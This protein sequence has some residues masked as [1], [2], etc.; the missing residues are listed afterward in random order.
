MGERR[1]W[2]QLAVGVL[3]TATWAAM[4]AASVFTVNNSGD[5]ADF[6][7]GDG[8]CE[9]ASGNG[10][11][12][13]RAAIEE[14]NALAAG[15]PHAIRFN[16]AMT[17]TAG[18][19]LP[20]VSRAGTAIDGATGN[21]GFAGAPVVVVVAGGAFDGLTMAG[22]SGEVRAL[23]LQ[24]FASAIVLASTGNLVRG[25]YIGTDASGS[26]AAANGT[27]LTVTGNGNT[28]GG[29][30]AADR[31]LISGN[32]AVGVLVGGA[33]SCTVQGNLIGLDVSGTTA[34]PNGT[35]GIHISGATATG[36]TVGGLVAGARNVISGHSGGNDAGIFL[37]NGAG[38]NVIQG[39][40]IGTNASGTTAVANYFGINSQS[41]SGNTLGG[42]SAAARNLVSGNSNTGVRLSGSSNNLVQ[43]NFIGLDASGTAALGNGNQGL[44][45]DNASGNTVGGAA[46]GAGNVI[47]GNG[48]V[49]VRLGSASNTTVQGNVIGMDAGATTVIDNAGGG[50]HVFGGT[51][52]RILGNVLASATPTHLGIDLDVD[53]SAPDD[54]VTAN[55]LDDPDTGSNQL[56][57]FPVLSAAETDGFQTDLTGSLNSLPSTTFRIEFFADPACHPLGHGAG[58]VV[59][60]SADVTTDAG[61]DAPIAV[62]LPIGVVVG[63]AVSATATDPA[64][65]TS[66]FSACVTAQA[67]SEPA[68]EPVPASSGPGLLATMLLLAAAGAWLLRVRGTWRAPAEGAR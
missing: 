45:I 57:N 58:R 53:T 31:N 40:Y 54:G 52:N 35:Y 33:Q 61:G 34:V 26:A 8:V 3:V 49:A 42:T 23:V 44:R 43:G 2:R 37:D 18:T 13:L 38:G 28:I 46:A 21:P 68:A 29:T 10:V 15:A 62:S 17:V 55:D 41:A 50:V 12:T 59:L 36:N 16:A 25:C 39:N 14:T 19:A 20:A 32:S 1:L 30:T 63:W 64:G 24:S 48:D 4:A 9:T 56:Q 66:E 27:G 6:S 22:G 67:P 5:G 51:G 60:G 7:T 11:C 65:N 47:A